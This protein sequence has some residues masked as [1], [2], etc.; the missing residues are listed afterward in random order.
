VSGGILVMLLL[1]ATQVIFC[2]PSCSSINLQ[3]LWEISLLKVMTDLAKIITVPFSLKSALSS[4][5]IIKARA[6][7]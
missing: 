3:F 4:H 7:Y 2:F 6:P 1:I 5:V